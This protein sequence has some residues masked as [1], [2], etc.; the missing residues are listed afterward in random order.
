LHIWFKSLLA[1][2]AAALLVLVVAV[3]YALHWAA[4]PLDLQQPTVVTLVPGEA[5]SEFAERLATQGVLE[6]PQVWSLVARAR[7]AARLAQAGEYEIAANDS[8]DDVLARLVRGDVVQYRVQ[9]LEGWTTM[10]ALAALR[11]HPVLHQELSGV[12][13]TTLLAALGLP[14]GHAEGLFFPDTYLFVRGASDADILRRAYAEMQDLLQDAWAARA[15]GLPYATPYDALIAASL[16]EKETGRDA[17]RPHISQVF[18]TRLQQNMRLQTDPSVIYGL[19][20]AFDGN[21]TRQHLRTDTPYNTYTRKGLPPTPIALPGAGSLAAALH[22]G[23]GDYLFFVSRGDGTSHFSRTLNEHNR[24]VTKYQ[25][26]AGKRRPRE[27]N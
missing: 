7:G 18:A 14:A 4:A 12:D 19:G 9:L 23:D 15:Q 25:L 17:D 6:H 26:P 20:S 8:P 16:I 13:V 10:Q 27:E 2:I 24:A 1:F 21:L 22:P 11:A 3:G 5:F